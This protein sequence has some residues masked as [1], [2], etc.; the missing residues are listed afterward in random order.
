[1][2]HH[3]RRE[4][5]P[6]GAL[7]TGSQNVITHEVNIG[8]FISVRCTLLLASS[9]SCSAWPSMSVKALLFG[10]SSTDPLMSVITIIAALC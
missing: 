2:T 4:Y 7:Q 10:P 9:T 1:V 5:S 6:I 8:C 3:E